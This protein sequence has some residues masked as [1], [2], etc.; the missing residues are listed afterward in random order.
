MDITD[1]HGR[2]YL[3]L[4]DC[5]PSRFAVWRSLR[6]QASA[7]VVQELE[8]VFCEHGA[9]EELLADND[10][11]FKSKTFAQLMV[12]WSVNLRF[13]CAYVPSGNKVIAARKCCSIAEAVYLYN[14]T[15]RDDRTT[16]SAPS[17]EIHRYDVRLRG[18][19]EPRKEEQP[20]DGPYAVGDKVWV[21]PPGARCDTRYRPG[22]VTGTLSRQAAVVNGTPR[23]VPDLRRRPHSEEAGNEELQTDDQD[24]DLIIYFPG[25]DQAGSDPATESTTGEPRRSARIRRPR[26][27]QSCD[28]YDQ[29]EGGNAGQ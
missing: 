6:L 3:T 19:D 2:P 26:L 23:H 24:D 9:P 7:D 22:V 11:A 25:E 5:G 12:R 21:K 20:K 16:Q 18:I 14:V 27:L 15:P 29:G 8:A 28:Q 17:S 4:I 13:R 1:Y 10:T